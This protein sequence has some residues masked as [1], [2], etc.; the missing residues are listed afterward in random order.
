[1]MQVTAMPMRDNSPFWRGG[2]G[3]ADAAAAI[4]L[5]RRPDF[6]P[7]LL[8]RLEAAADDSVQR[9]RAWK[10]QSGDLWSYIPLPVTA[11]GLDSYTVTVDVP[12]T[13]KAFKAVAAYPGL[14]LV[15]GSI[16]DYSITVKDA[17]GKEVGTTTASGDAGLSTLFVDLIHP[18]LD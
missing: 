5:V 12:A 2:Y 11:F 9:D 10:V 8:A 6:G 17:A 3:F 13:T 1:V 18:T 14:A 7:G 16:F 4:A 15:G